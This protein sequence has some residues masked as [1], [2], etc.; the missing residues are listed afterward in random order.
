MNYDAFFR[1]KLDGLRR[2]GRYRVFVDIERKAGAFPRAI[3]HRGR[4]RH[5]VT[6]WCSN[7]YLGMGQH[8]SVVEAMQEALRSYGAGA[9]GTRNISGNCHAHVLLEEELAD[10]HDKEAALLFT[11]GYVSNWATLST[12]A[13]GL[14]GCVVL[15]DAGNHAS[16]IEGIR[17]SGAPKRIF[18]HND[19]ADLDRKLADLD[20]QAAKLVAF[21]SVYSMDGDVA[22]IAEICDVAERHGAMT[23]LDEVHAVGL[24]GRR[25]GGIAEREGLSHRLTLIEGTLGKAFGT[26]GGYIAASAALCDYVRSFASGYIFTTSLPPAVAA[27]ARASIRHLKTSA[28]ERLRQQDR[29][30]TVRR[31][32]DEAGVPHLANP[33][34]IV[35]VMVGDPVICKLIGDRLLDQYGIYVQPINYPTV[36]R[37]TERLRLTPSPLHSDE[38]VDHLITSLSEIWS[39]FGLCRAA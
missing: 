26:V 22:P 4:Q 33:S 16:M 13:S 2:E 15:S 20:P 21:E 3:H 10:L 1:G 6:V 34:H 11:S 24:Y 7:D 36:P 38:D 32:L 17:H 29:V 27:G 35:P 37:G 30:A 5:E 9:G 14:P 28:L 23:Y 12:L 19:P 18:A 31:R 25:G 8:P 39:D